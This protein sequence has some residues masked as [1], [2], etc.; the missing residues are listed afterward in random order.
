MLIEA[1]QLANI[2]FPELIVIKG[3]FEKAESYNLIRMKKQASSY[4]VHSLNVSSIL[5]NFAYI[6]KQLL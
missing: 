6:K 1:G 3:G 5:I 4:K 2:D